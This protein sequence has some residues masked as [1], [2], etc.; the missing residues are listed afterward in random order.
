M[1]WLLIGVLI[2][3]AVAIPVALVIGRSIRLAEARR[4]QEY[5]AGH[6][7]NF[8]ATDAPPATVADADAADA[9]A[10]DATATAVPATAG[11][12]EHEEQPWTGPS[13]VPFAPSRL[14]WGG[15]RA[16]GRRAGPSALRA[17][18]AQV[19]PTA[20]RQGSARD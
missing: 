3:I 19:D 10:T 18:A 13:T 15:Q 2:W 20:P 5:Q 16:S 4:K 7:A 17:H 6:E 11:T 12:A 1:T 14:P 8:V 9:T